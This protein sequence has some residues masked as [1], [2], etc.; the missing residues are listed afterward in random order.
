MTSVQND[1][2]AAPTRKHVK[3]GGGAQYHEAFLAKAR[4][5]L[6]A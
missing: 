1:W 3:R 2:S 5:F 4:Q 6:A